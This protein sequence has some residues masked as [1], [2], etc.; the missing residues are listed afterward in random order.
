[1]QKMHMTVDEIL[2]PV[3][4]SGCLGNSARQYD[5]LK[6]LLTEKKAGQAQRIKAYSIA[7]DVLGRGEDF[8]NSLDSIVRVEMHRLRKNLS[9]F[10]ATSNNF[11]LTIPKAC[12][13]VEISPFHPK[14][15]PISRHIP[16]TR[17][18][19][20]VI[21]SFLLL[22]LVGI[23]IYWAIKS[24]PLKPNQ[25]TYMCSKKVPNLHLAPTTLVGSSK[26]GND[27]ALIIDNYLRTGLAQYSMINLVFGI[28]D[29][30]TAGTPFYTLQTEVFRAA[31]QPFISV[32]VQYNNQQQIVF[33]QKIEIPKQSIILSEQ[34]SW[35][36]YKI[37]SKLTYTS[38]IIPHDAIT[39]KWATP[40][41][42]Y[43]YQ[44]QA[45]AHRYFTVAG[46]SKGYRDA[47][48]CME[49]T[50]KNGNK[51]PDLHGLLAMFYMEQARG[52]QPVHS[53]NPLQ[54]AE[55][56]LDLAEKTTPLNTQVLIARLRLESERPVI[57]K[58]ELKHTLYLL[59]RQQPHNPH[60]LIF[61]SQI[62]GFKIGEWQY[63]KKLSQTTLRLDQ[64]NLY[65]LYYVDLAY[66]LLFSNTQ[67]AYEISLK[68]HEPRSIIAGVMGLATANKAG[69]ITHANQ[70]KDDLNALGLSSIPDYIAF[71]EGRNYESRLTE[72][73]M[74]WVSVP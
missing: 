6:Y 34:A 43:A 20:F 21:A 12:Y 31:E 67:E 37:A 74:K 35:Q 68:L 19:L 11:T 52:Y 2:Q 36:F 24:A 23:L 18:S 53:E 46:S 70:Y 60:A 10:N 63:A 32:I 38:G 5:L 42:K 51:S 71:I 13:L 54:S 33:S 28:T 50:I 17:K 30:K 22:S 65:A 62:A 15:Q 44:C 26:L 48:Q 58:E 41:Y 25:T 72:E 64:T 55:K 61:A 45:L 73:L 9:L 8:D 7:I 29:C 66:A 40:A 16:K 3:F 27:T 47:I 49:T 57:N 59:E 39:R 4:Q 14:T 56:L 1:M 69:K